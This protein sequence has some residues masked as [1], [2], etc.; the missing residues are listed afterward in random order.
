M[1]AGTEWQ[2]WSSKDKTK[3]SI[4]K[5]REEVTDVSIQN[6]HLS[7]EFQEK[8]EVIM[9]HDNYV[10][11]DEHKQLTSKQRDS[12]NTTPYKKLEPD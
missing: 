11:W 1:P 12:S 3:K 6:I 8:E 5:I 9:S 2:D 7:N 4:V 10:K